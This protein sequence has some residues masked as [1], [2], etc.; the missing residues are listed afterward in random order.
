VALGNLKS[1][2][3][4]H[5]T[6]AQEQWSDNFL[7]ND[8]TLVEFTLGGANAFKDFVI[9][10][11]RI[12]EVLTGNNL[13]GENYGKEANNVANWEKASNSVLQDY[14]RRKKIGNIGLKSVRATKTLPITEGAYMNAPV[15]SI[16]ANGGLA[17]VIYGMGKTKGNSFIDQMYDSYTRAIWMMWVKQNKVALNNTI[18]SST[19]PDTKFQRRASGAS[20]KRGVMR[21]TTIIKTFRTGAK[22]EHSADTTTAS[23]AVRALETAGL[24][25]QYNNVNIAVLDIVQHLKKQI[26]IDWA[27]T[28]TKANVG[29][30]KSK[31]LIKLSLGKNPTNLK[32][33]LRNI[34]N[35]AEEYITDTLGKRMTAVL[36][37]PA[38]TASVSLSD[39]VGGDVITDVL[40]PLTKAGLP[41]MRYKVNVA[42][43]NTKP[44]KENIQKSKGPSKA[45]ITA[46]SIAVKGKM[47]AKAPK[48]KQ[49]EKGA[50]DLLKLEA[51]INKRLP[52]QVRKNM[53]RP[54]LINQTGRFANSVEVQNFRETKAG[55]S[56]EYTY[57]LSP[58]ETFENTGSVRWPAG[59]N[60]KPLIAKSIRELAMGLT[61]Q[62][63]ASLRRI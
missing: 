39:Q 33:D 23:Q 27:L 17:I 54:A 2:F 58:Y 4:K 30:Y 29:V 59:Y 47:P 45:L 21:N 15:N 26:Q 41:D 37:N 24:D 49:R 5:L 22:R 11:N 50:G 31:H 62:K 57:Q 20:G 48:E 32:S 42:K 38:F 12:V 44:R 43:F 7:P 19:T 25:V 34:M 1:K 18:L 35:S 10:T 53:G 36:G 14:A 28:Q 8:K 56:G 6:D 63:L 3:K 60:P 40:R 55:V 46:A 13:F 61:Q 52:Q 16:K 51:M 9:S